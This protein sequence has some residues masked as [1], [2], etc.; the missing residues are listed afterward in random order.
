MVQWLDS[1]QGSLTSDYIRGPENSF[2]VCHLW[3]FG[4]QP[5]LLC[6]LRSCASERA[7]VR[8]DGER[9]T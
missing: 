4:T 2:R 7:V 1:L 5:S 3:Q 8:E 9:L 6:V